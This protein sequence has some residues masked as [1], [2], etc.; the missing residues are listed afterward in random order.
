MIITALAILGIAVT[1]LVASALV[2]VTRYARDLDQMTV[3]TQ[4]AM[5]D[6]GR[7]YSREHR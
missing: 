3:V 1:I 6:I 4:D 7:H 5:R 2:N